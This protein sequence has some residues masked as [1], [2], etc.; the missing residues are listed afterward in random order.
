MKPS[1]ALI[2]TKDTCPFTRKD[3]RR[4]YFEGHQ[5]LRQSFLD[6]PSNPY[7]DRSD[8]SLYRAWQRGHD[9][10]AAEQAATAKDCP[11]CGGGGI[12]P[13]RD[14]PGVDSECGTCEGGGRLFFDSEPCQ[15]REPA[16]GVC[17]VRG[18]SPARL[19][20]QEAS[21]GGIPTTPP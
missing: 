3:C 20:E 21:E 14:Y 12:L 7:R 19:S 1:P 4:A 17:G 16:P 2:D 9:D 10:A 13:I 5:A 6:N 8:P 11:D 15:E 18:V